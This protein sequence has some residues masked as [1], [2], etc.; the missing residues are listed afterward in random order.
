[1]SD[2]LGNMVYKKVKIFAGYIFCIDK[3]FL[4]SL[5]NLSY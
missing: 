2:L 1:M 3:L 4:F 5:K